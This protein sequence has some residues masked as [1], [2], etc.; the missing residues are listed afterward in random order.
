MAQK[1]NQSTIDIK[2]LTI[3]ILI[4]LLKSMNSDPGDKLNE[5]QPKDGDSD[6]E[7]LF[8]E[9]MVK[10]NSEHKPPPKSTVSKYRDLSQKLG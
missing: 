3:K 8:D 1:S 9:E 2:L 5:K 4:S 10:K 6:L 7:D